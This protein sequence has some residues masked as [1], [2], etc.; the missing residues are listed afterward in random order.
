VK[1]RPPQESSG[2]WTFDEGE[3]RAAF[4]KHTKA[5]IVNTPNNPT[6]KVFTRAELELIRDLCVEFDVLA[7]TDEIYE[8]ILYDGTK[9][10]SMVS[11]PG[12]EERTITIN[13]MS[14]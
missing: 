1:L 7:I 13:G 3:L 4:Q 10:I 11:L 14:S 8:H 5:I 9:H 2:E 12:M 6:G